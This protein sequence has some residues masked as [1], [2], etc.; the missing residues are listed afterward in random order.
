MAVAE[1]VAWKQPAL[2]VGLVVYGDQYT[3]QA[4]ALAWAKRQGWKLVVVNNQPEGAQSG[5]WQGSNAHF[6]FSGYLEALDQM[7]GPGPFLLINDTFFYNHATRLWCRAL[8]HWNQR[9]VRQPTQEVWIL[10]DVRREKEVF[11]EKD[12]NFL[13]SW[14]FYL[15][16]RASLEVLAACLSQLT[17]EEL[18]E[19]SIGYQTYVNRWL[20][21]N[22]PWRGWH[23]QRNEAAL[24]RKRRVIRLEHRLSQLLQQGGWMQGADE[25]LVWYPLLRLYERFKTRLLAISSKSSKK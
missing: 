24:A 3:S 5:Q 20:Q 18:P 15:P 13:A 21:S 14:L 16:N 8:H 10:G 6:E 1:P 17:T 4:K 9:L 23:G 2:T 11:P 25:Y 19:P 22:G 7:S 12:A